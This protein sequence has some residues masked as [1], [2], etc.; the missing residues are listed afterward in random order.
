[1]DIKQR[2]GIAVRNRRK[3]IGIS[4]EELAMRINTDV[5]DSRKYADQSYISKIEL[6]Q[7]NITLETV[8]I[9]A[10]ALECGVGEL[11]G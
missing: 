2:F 5:D 4:Q 7:M 9:L 1:M 11:F 10:E 6:G 8:D 3:E